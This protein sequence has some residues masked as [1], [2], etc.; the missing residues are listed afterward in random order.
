MSFQQVNFVEF[1]L[2]ILMVTTLTSRSEKRFRMCL[3][4]VDKLQCTTTGKCS[5]NKGQHRELNILIKN[6]ELE[7]AEMKVQYPNQ[8]KHTFP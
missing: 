1:T 3:L 7:K 6:K 2:I 8:E 5:Q 4:H